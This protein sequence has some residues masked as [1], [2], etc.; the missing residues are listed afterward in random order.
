[1]HQF[2]TRAKAYLITLA[3]SSIS[4]LASCASIQ[5]LDPIVGETG[6]PLSEVAQKSDVKR[7]E[8][9]LEI[10][11]RSKRISGVGHTEFLITQNTDRLELKLDS[12][13]AISK[14]EISKQPAKFERVDGVITVLLDSQR[15]A[16]DVVNVSI[17]YSGKPHVAL[18]APWQGGFVWGETDDGQPW[19]ATAVQ[20]E[21][22]DLFWPCKDHFSDKADEMRIKLTVPKT[23]TAVTNGVLQS[24]RL[25]GED[26]HQ[27][28]WLLAVPA[29][30]YNIAL[31][32]GPYARIQ[33]TYTSVNGLDIPLEFWALTENQ[34]K[35]L[36]LID[37]D[38]VQQIEW[39]EQRLGP[40][41]WGT[42]KI[43]FVETPHLGMEHQTINAYGK[44]YK[45]DKNGYDWLLH[46][47]LAH[48]WFGN[49]M[50]HQQL[51]D[52][53]LHEGF[54]LYMQPA[55][56]LDKF[57][58]A[59][60]Q[61]R[62]YV[63]YL[64]LQNCEPVV[65]Q[66]LVSNDQ[67]FSSDIYDKGAWTLHTL[68]WLLGDDAFWNAT[69]ELV[70]GTSDTHKLNYP[71]ASRYRSTDD[72]LQIVNRVGGQDYAWLFDVYLKQAELPEL[73]EVRTDDQLILTWKTPEELH[74]PMPVPVSINGELM[75]YQ[76]ENGK[77]S[78]HLGAKDKVIID[79]DMK[80]LRYL[81]IIGLCEENKA[82]LD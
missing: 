12:R 14:V 65:Q 6:Q 9:E 2:Q 78:I 35:A 23:L 77:I 39:F 53:W 24:V 34:E 62:M 79:P 46:H 4:F 61:Y 68:R 30:D 37:D 11:P 55:Y 64:R 36:T 26:K 81:P 7:Y 82:K 73:T 28:D 33:K 71:I 45:R 31:N 8:L 60:Y 70:Y 10:F 38:I 3:L 17:H 58:P 69:R 57:G 47:E 80:V 5:P 48:E 13:F 50:T 22:C 54:G 56:M 74:F 32:I 44:Q 29:S 76:P 66:G 42:Q 75:V 43:G 20:G 27:F 63:A 67:A 21:G 25:V 59:A 49:L 1:M 41:P 52:A 51:N 18:N 19:I 40:Y 72:F 16:G 15:I